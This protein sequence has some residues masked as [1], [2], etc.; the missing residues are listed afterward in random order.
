MYT[1]KQIVPRYYIKP[2]CQTLNVYVYHIIIGIYLI[3]LK[4]HYVFVCLIIQGIISHVEN[5][6]ISIFKW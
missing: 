4:S 6:H 1:L 2:N 5:I 3:L